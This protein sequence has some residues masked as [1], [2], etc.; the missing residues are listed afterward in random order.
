M[1]CL[2]QHICEDCI[3]ILVH[4]Q[5]Q[6]GHIGKIVLRTNKGQQII[7]VLC[8]RCTLDLRGYYRHIDDY[9]SDNVAWTVINCN[10]LLA[11][12]YNRSKQ[13]T[14][15]ISLNATDVLCGNEK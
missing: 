10:I 6:T 15:K 8:C 3:L 13:W 11:S 4:M 1:E 2:D 5:V 14:V 12:I 7:W 9:A